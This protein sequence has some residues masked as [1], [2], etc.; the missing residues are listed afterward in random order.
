MNPHAKKQTLKKVEGYVWC[1]KHGV[2]HEDSL[3]PY[4]YGPPTQAG[5]DDPR[6]TKQDHR[7]VYARH[8]P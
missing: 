4:D 1:N 6:C 2:V 5:F 8:E 7:S 3:D